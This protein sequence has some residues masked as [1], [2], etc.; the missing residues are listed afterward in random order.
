MVP[1]ITALG[2]IWSSGSEVEVLLGQGRLGGRRLFCT[3]CWTSSESHCSPYSA[4][5]S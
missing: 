1:G 2:R 5:T 3:H 4:F